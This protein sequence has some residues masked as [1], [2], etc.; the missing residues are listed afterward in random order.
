VQGFAAHEGVAL[1]QAL[2]GRTDTASITVVPIDWSQLMAARR[3][4]DVSLFAMRAPASATSPAETAERLAH[5]TPHE[6]RAW[7]EPIVRDAVAQV[8]KLSAARID[9]RKPFGSMGLNSLLAMELRNRLEAALGRPLS[10][11]LAFNYP[12]I[13]ALVGFLCGEQ[14]AAAAPARPSSAAAVVAAHEEIANLSDDEAALLLR[15]QR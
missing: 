6:R 15:R 11:T 8:L 10:A 2:A 5:A 13:D 7:M 14:P 9:M 4:R 1:L 3:G 12:T